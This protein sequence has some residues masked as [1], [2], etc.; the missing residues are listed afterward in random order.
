[1]TSFDYLNNLN[2]LSLS[3]YPLI[4][5]WVVC[6]A[7]SFSKSIFSCIHWLLSSS[8]TSSL[9]L[10]IIS[11]SLILTLAE[12][13]SKVFWASSSIRNLTSCCFL[14]LRPEVGPV[15]VQFY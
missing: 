8:I 5:T 4:I 13:A 2:N 6:L 15:F 12:S 11:S 14:S 10:S 1:M 9:L 7:C 3:L